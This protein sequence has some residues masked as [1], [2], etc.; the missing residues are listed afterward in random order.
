MATWRKVPGTN[1]G[2]VLVVPALQILNLLG[3]IV[4]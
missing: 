1:A 3:L 2:K 4:I